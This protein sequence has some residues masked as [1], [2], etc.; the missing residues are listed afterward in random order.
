MQFKP[1]ALVLA[2]PTASGKTA[3]AVR[4]VEQADFEIISVDS[5]LVYRGLD[6]G[7][8]KPDA[9]TLTIAPHHLID[10]RHPEETY[11]A[12]EFVNDAL[13]VMADIQ[14]RGKTPLLTGGTFMY[15]KAL[16][17]GL[18]ELPPADASIR[19]K[20]ESEARD[21]GWPQL[22]QQLS[23]FDPATAA[24]IDEND[25]QRIQRAIEVYRI[26]GRSLT[27]LHA[28]GTPLTGASE[29]HIDWLALMPSDRAWLHQRIARRL[30]IMLEH[31]F[32]AEVEA[33]MTRSRLS[34]EHPAMRS[35]GYRQYWAYLNGEFSAE[36]AYQK[37]LAATRQLAKR[38]MTWMRGESRFSLFDP[39][40]NRI[41]DR[42]SH[43][44]AQ[45]RR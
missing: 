42:M 6:I 41:F 38:Q 17:G 43:F 14:Q 3:L 28:R 8:A 39:I 18:H 33:L 45:M 20:I 15:L 23:K 2:G 31:G 35:V 25:R 40:D 11:S 5:A 27:D 19:A 4:L 37:T 10:I 12:G 7:T 30:D 1:R 26:S 16:G 21:V 34:A 36:D 29:W 24:R 32:V 44:V 22:H 13:A 9:D